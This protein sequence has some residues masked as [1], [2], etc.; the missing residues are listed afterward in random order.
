MTHKLKP[1]SEV[2]IDALSKK[3]RPLVKD[4]ITQD[5]TET[6]KAVEGVVSEVR[7]LMPADHK[8]IDERISFYAAC[9]EVESR[10]QALF[11]E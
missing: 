1:A 5:R 4:T 3:D 8:N 11:T 10:L 7:E 2:V 6:L 9:N